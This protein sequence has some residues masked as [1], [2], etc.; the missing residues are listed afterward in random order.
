MP[1]HG[2]IMFLTPMGTIL[3]TKVIVSAA[4]DPYLAA[5]AELKSFSSMVL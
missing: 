4:L 1:G 2:H 5:V 3:D